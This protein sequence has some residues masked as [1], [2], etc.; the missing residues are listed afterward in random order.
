MAKISCTECIRT[1]KD[2]IEKMYCS[3]TGKPA[4]ES[5]D[6]PYYSLE[7]ETETSESPSSAPGPEVAESAFRL[8]KE[9][10]DFTY[11][12]FGGIPVA[13]ALSV[14]WAG[15]T[16]ITKQQNGITAIITGLMAGIS[17]MV[18][19]GGISRK[20]GYL[21]AA[22]A[23]T[24]CFLGNF[25]S[26]IVFISQQ[27][28]SGY[29]ATLLN[30]SLAEAKE[31][32]IASYDPID[33][34]F[35]ALAVYGGYRMSFRRIS[36]SSIHKIAGFE[37]SVAPGFFRYRPHILAVA[38]IIIGSAIYLSSQSVNGNRTLYY[39]SG[40]EQAAGSF[41]DSKRD[42]LWIYY[43]EN[44]SVQ[45]K[46]CYKAGVPDSA[47][48]WYYP[49]GSLKQTGFYRNGLENGTWISYYPTGNVMDSGSYDAGKRTGRWVSRY[50]SGLPAEEGMYEYDLKTGLWNSFYPNGQLKASGNMVL[51][52]AGGTWKY[53]HENGQPSEEIEYAGNREIRFIHSWA[54]DGKLMVKSGNG[55]HTVI[56]GNGAIL[57]QGECSGFR[58]TGTW[59]SWFINGRLK[60]NGIYRDGEYL[61]MEAWN[62]IG[63]IQVKDGQGRYISYF[64]DDS[65]TAMTGQIQK[66]FRT[67]IWRIYSESSILS[68]ELRYVKNH[69]NGKAR[70]FYA[71]GSL[72]SEG[73]FEGDKKQ[74][75]W[76]WYYPD[77]RLKSDV[78]YEN[79]LKQGIQNSYDQA[80]TLRVTEIYK[81]GKRITINEL[82]K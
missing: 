70:Y 82:N 1:Q 10:E 28:F 42:G 24:A 33:F 32:I 43:Y 18:L 38:G 64:A 9:S 81:D 16:V 53:Y 34:A 26:Q 17:I 48:Q 19:G 4:E 8:V 62:R 30:T 77:G 2:G 25:F 69:L 14:V 46:G 3:V 51:N 74:G 36:A 49:G 44:H 21:G 60:E 35:Y 54:E 7:E 67:G 6:C 56:A 61:V 65:T 40:S 13:L 66:G 52:Y 50:P 20:F 15:I 55:I 76:A 79:D 73:M 78:Q 39:P 58:R 23:F 63:E 68:Q 41:L 45:S 80:G 37:R 5:S 72:Y 11:A 31:I 75:R 71:D 57:L 27:E 59:K 29:R 47:W 12:L 22:Y